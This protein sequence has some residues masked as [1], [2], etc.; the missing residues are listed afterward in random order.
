M[1]TGGIP[2]SE[3]AKEAGIDMRTLTRWIAAG[4]VSAPKIQ[5]RGGRAVRLWKSSDLAR[6]RK[7][8]QKIY[9]KGRGRKP[10]KGQE[11]VK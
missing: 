10:V 11:E 5:L 2:T 7:V 9:R 8:K 4:Q 3:A 1:R 6:L